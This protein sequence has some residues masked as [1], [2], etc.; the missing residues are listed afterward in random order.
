MV[1]A[2]QALLSG[3]RGM[4]RVVPRWRAQQQR[5]ANPRRCRRSTAT[6]SRP[7][8]GMRRRPPLHEVY[9]HICGHRAIALGVHMHIYCLGYISLLPYHAQFGKQADCTLCACRLARMNRAQ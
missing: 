6:P 7:M 1:A 2:L 5:M 4:P 8:S 3:V 9:A